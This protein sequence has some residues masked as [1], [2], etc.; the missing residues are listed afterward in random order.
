MLSK[1]KAH[2]LLQHT[3]KHGQA[4]LTK[5]VCKCYHKYMAAMTSARRPLPTCFVHI[6]KGSAYQLTKLLHNMSII[7]APN[8]WDFL[9]SVCPH[10]ESIKPSPYLNMMSPH[11]II[12]VQGLSWFA[13]WWVFRL[14]EENYDGRAPCNT[15]G[16]S[17][18]IS[19]LD[20]VCFLVSGLA[21]YN[22]YCNRSSEHKRRFSGHVTQSLFEL[23]L[24]IHCI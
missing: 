12:A 15:I 8:E 22:Y 16:I 11:F 13:I 17:V 1:L 21:H 4:E 14:V 5:M 19:M 10:L 20:Y 9:H 2:I 6:L 7:W 24:F 18:Y 23:C 3:N